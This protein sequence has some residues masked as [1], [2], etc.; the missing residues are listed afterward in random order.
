MLTDENYQEELIKFI[1]THADPYPVMIEVLGSAV[2]AGEVAHNIGKGEEQISKKLH[3][4]M[5]DVLA[6]EDPS[7]VTLMGP[8]I[9]NN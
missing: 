8:D 6:K 2:M 9:S 5:V 7:S 1:A 4:A 3:K